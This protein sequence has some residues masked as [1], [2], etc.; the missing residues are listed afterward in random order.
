[1]SS[2][3]LFVNGRVNRGF[4]CSN[5]MITAGFR[6][7]IQTDAQKWLHNAQISSSLPLLTIPLLYYIFNLSHRIWEKSKRKKK[8]LQIVRTFSLSGA[9]EKNWGICL[10]L[11]AWDCLKI[12]PMINEL[13]FK[14]KL[15]TYSIQMIVL[16]GNPRMLQGTEILNGPDCCIK[17]LNSKLKV[18]VES[19]W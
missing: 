2:N 5:N 9:E 3:F 18:T 1:M 16:S 19:P 7:Q 8:D 13:I 17:L 4:C 12:E 11:H 14:P 10:F 15:L 6:F